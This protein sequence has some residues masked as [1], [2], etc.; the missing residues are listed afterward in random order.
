MTPGPLRFEGRE[1]PVLDGDT[2]A[3]A[4][5]RSGVRTFSRSLKGHRRRGLYCGTGECPNCLLTV[6]GV[7]AVRSCVTPAAGGMRVRR[8]H[9]WPSVERDVLSILDRMHVL[10]PVGFY[11][12]TFIRPRWLW[13]VA[14]RIIRRTVGLGRLPD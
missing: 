13:G 9:G 12:K 4:L 5:F 10:L 1:V 11:Y 7:P 6:D 2:V 8:E 3:S 14:D